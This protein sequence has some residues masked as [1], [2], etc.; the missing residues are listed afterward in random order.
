MI[1]EIICPI[2]VAAAAPYMPHLK[3]RTNTASNTILMT[4]P[5]IFTN[6]AIF[7]LPSARM[8]C[9]LPIVKIRN[10]NPI[11]VTR[12]YWRASGRTFDGE[13][14]PISRGVRKSSVIRNRRMP[15]VISIIM[16]FPTK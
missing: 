14:K 4:A 1:V 10:G 8:R 12:T 6:M 13:P 15:V 2:T 16:E 7:G 9:P 11:A 3:I 5:E